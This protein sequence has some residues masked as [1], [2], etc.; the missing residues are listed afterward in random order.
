MARVGER[1]VLT[2]SAS[3]CAGDV[4]FRWQ[5]LKDRPLYGRMEKNNTASQQIFDPVGM[6]H[7]GKV[8]CLA[9]CADPKDQAQR[10]ASVEVYAFPKDPIISGS[11]LLTEGQD[12]DLTCTVPD[13]YP[14][15]RLKVQWLLGDKVL[16]DNKAVNPV[17][18]GEAQ[19]VTSVLKYKPTA[20]DHGQNVTCRATLDI[21]T[22]PET[23]E[24]VASI[25]VQSPFIV[26]LTLENTVH[27]IG[28][29]LKLI[30][31]TI[32]CPDTVSFTWSPSIGG[33]A[34]DQSHGTGL[35]TLKP[36][37]MEH[38]GPVVCNATCRASGEY[39]QASIDLEVYSFP[40]DPIIS[41]SE[42]LT[43]GQDSDLTCTVP[44]VYPADHLKVQWLL[45]DKVLNDDK[46]VNPVVKGEA[47]TVTSVLKYKPTAQDHGQNVTCRATLDIKTE[48]ETRETVASM[49]IRTP[50]RYLSVEVFPSTKVEEGQNVSLRIWAVGVPL[51]SV[52]LIRLQDSVEPHSPNGTLNLIDMGPVETGQYLLKLNNLGPEQTG[53]Y[54]LNLTNVGPDQMGQYL[55]NLNNVGPDQMGQYLLNLNN[56]GPEQTGQYLLNLTNEV[57]HQSHHFSLSVQSKTRLVG[58]D[59]YHPKTV[60]IPAVG[61]VSIA[62]AAGFLI[63]FLKKR[64]SYETSRV[65]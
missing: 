20:Q 47:Q 30:C 13:V 23:R 26:S 48:P 60:V 36:V 56:L 41:G 8:S 2:C 24:T 37:T 59:W 10:S 42:L 38:K 33:S 22:E 17:V 54:L 43:E 50:P 64:N 45:G 53:Q 6:Q 49:N 34:E 14:A 3:E 7:E 63:R 51:P 61:L 58:P 18:K 35:L 32:G 16:K 40:K 21:K 31:V 19:T 62:T 46:A 15:D 5:S 27:H 44:D 65:V 39:R 11:E 9:T 12:S 25:T 55:L 52:T 29:T 4:T 28:D 1:L 57:G